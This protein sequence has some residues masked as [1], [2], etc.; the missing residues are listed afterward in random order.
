[1]IPE[2]G[3]ILVTRRS[4]LRHDS[5]SESPSLGDNLRWGVGWGVTLA[6]IFSLFVAVMAGLRGST[7]YEDLGNLTTWHAVVYYYAAGVTGGALV[8]LLRPTHDHY[9]G[10]FLSA[11]LTLLLV[12]GGGSVALLP[13]MRPNDAD[14]KSTVA[15]LPLWAV[16]CL[17]LAPVYVR[18]TRNW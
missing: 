13:I 6:T 14:L 16:L 2:F 5:A 8:G 11:Y 10:K 9:W 1:M 15:L 18:I 3:R 4:R 12:Y 17:V 7:A